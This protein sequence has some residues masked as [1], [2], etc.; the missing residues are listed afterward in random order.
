MSSEAAPGGGSPWGKFWLNLRLDAR[1]L[2][3]SHVPLSSR[4]TYLARK[5]VAIAGDHRQIRFFD[6]AFHYDNRLTPALLPDYLDEVAHLRRAIGAGTVR[7]ILDV[8][9]NVGQFAAAWLRVDPEVRVHSFEPNPAAFALLVRNANGAPGWTCHPFGLGPRAGPVDF[10]Y[11][12][13]KS[14]QGSQYA[15]NATQGLWRARPRRIIVDLITLDQSTRRTLNVPD[16]VDLVKIDVEGAEREVL[17]ALCDLS[18][19]YVW[20]ELA[21]SRDGALDLAGAK[22]AL[23]GAGSIETLYAGPPVGPGGTYSALFRRS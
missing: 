11:A 19:T 4:L 17:T 23:S 12:E 1:W 2:R 7:S 18:W 10:H 8:G 5:Y 20:I 13:G 3:A 15:A 6:R 16:H 22:A 14:S 21:T 9:A